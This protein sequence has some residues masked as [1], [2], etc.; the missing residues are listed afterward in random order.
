MIFP[1]FHCKITF[2]IKLLELYISINT[3]KY[4][5][6]YI[7]YI[8]IYIQ[9]KGNVDFIKHGCI[10]LISFSLFKYIVFLYFLK[11][12]GMYL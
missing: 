8:Y 3:Y 10:I 11:M 5:Y 6:I 12:K 4:L 2:N 7:I 9:D 1:I